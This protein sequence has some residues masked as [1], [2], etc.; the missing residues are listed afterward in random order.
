[1]LPDALASVACAVAV[2]S[3]AATAVGAAA[4]GSAA[5]DAVDSVRL[6]AN[7]RA[8]G[9]RSRARAFIVDLFIQ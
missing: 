5:L 6:Q 7:S 4:V 8:A 2:G 1:L 9:S 3:G